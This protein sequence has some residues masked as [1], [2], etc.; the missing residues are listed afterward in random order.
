MQKYLNITGDQLTHWI[1]TRKLIEPAI[2][3]I[4][5]G[6]R[7]M[8]SFENLLDCA[9]IQELSTIGVD[10]HSIKAI[11]EGKKKI[12]SFSLGEDL[13]EETKLAKSMS[14]WVVF[15]EDRKLHEKE[16][17]WLVIEKFRGEFY[18]IYGKG[19]KDIEQLKHFLKTGDLIASK[20]KIIVS[21]SGIISEFELMTGQ[22]L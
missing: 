17:L 10:L 6:G 22:K 15:K 4:G 14:P 16:G 18:W 8:F 7:S 12:W 5:R 19:K 1:R 13:R 20:A 21:I 11:L 9:L 3:G 2:K